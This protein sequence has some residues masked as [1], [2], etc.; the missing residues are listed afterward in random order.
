[1]PAIVFA[2]DRPLFVSACGVEFREKM[3]MLTYSGV[4]VHSVFVCL[5]VNGA[6]VGNPKQTGDTPEGTAELTLQRLFS[7][8]RTSAVLPRDAS[9]DPTV[10]PG[11]S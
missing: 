10:K 5:Q 2:T 11:P 1:M 8:A 7:P 6:G 3:L 9:F 4:P